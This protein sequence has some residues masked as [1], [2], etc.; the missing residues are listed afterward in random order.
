MFELTP[1]AYVL[2][3]KPQF[4]TKLPASASQ[5]EGAARALGLPTAIASKTRPAIEQDVFMSVFMIPTPK[6]LRRPSSP[7]AAFRYR[8]TLFLSNIRA[9]PKIS[10]FQGE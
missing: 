2:P 10:V 8:V 3:S 9:T 5:T 1:V 4:W 6:A 7:M